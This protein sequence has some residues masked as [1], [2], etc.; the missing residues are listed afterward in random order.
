MG[1]LVRES[2]D[3]SGFDPALVGSVLLG[4]GHQAAGARAAL[5][6]AAH[7]ATQEEPARTARRRVARR[8]AL[9]GRRGRHGMLPIR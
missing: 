2:R 9:W 8:D 7:A 4:I 5:A 1:R 3:L 6:S